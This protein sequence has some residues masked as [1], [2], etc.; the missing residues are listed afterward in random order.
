M[1]KN[2]RRFF[3]LSVVSKWYYIGEIMV[4]EIG[5]Y[6]DMFNIYVDMKCGYCFI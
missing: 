3:M 4:I 5:Y 2:K 1:Y 6:K